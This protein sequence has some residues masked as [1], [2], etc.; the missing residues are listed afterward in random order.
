MMTVN[1]YIHHKHLPHLVEYFKKTG[2]TIQPTKSASEVFR[3]VR[4]DHRRPVLLYRKNDTDFLVADSRDMKILTKFMMWYN[5]KGEN[6]MNIKELETRIAYMEKDIKAIK[7]ALGIVDI[8]SAQCIEAPSVADSA[9]V[10]AEIT[11]IL[12]HIGVPAHLKGYEQIR[13]A[14]IMCVNDPT[15]LECITKGLYPGVADIVH[16]T[17]SRVERAIRHAVESAWDRGDLDVL[18]HY[19]GRAIDPDKGKPTNGQFIATLVDYIHMKGANN[20]MG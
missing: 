12:R 2:W 1:N 9:W 13:Q 19:F 6:N 3:A 4:R 10:K 5:T 15:L 14:I 7:A 16:T 18:D 11:R 20:E 8:S 17:P